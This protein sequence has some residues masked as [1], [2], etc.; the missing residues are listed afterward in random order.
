MHSRDGS[1]CA[2]HDHQAFEGLN[3]SVARKDRRAGRA[4]ERLRLTTPEQFSRETGRPLTEVLSR[5]EAV[6]QAQ[7]EERIRRCRDLV[8]RPHEG[9]DMPVETLGLGFPLDD[10][11]EAHELMAPGVSAQL[12]ERLRSWQEGWDER[13]EYRSGRLEF[14]AG[15]PLSVRLARQLQSELPAHRNYLD[16]QGE[17][18]PA[19]DL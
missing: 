13:G 19:E 2:D 10:Q 14:T 16:V 15:S 12:I 1:G 3:T 6:T 18:R 4:G 17:L 5:M 9:F 11:L 7:A 8:M